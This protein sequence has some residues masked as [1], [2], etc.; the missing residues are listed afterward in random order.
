MRINKIDEA[1]FDQKKNGVLPISMDE[2]FDLIPSR[3]RNGKKVI[4]F[5]HE[6]LLPEF[7]AQGKAYSY[8]FGI[9]PISRLMSDIDGEFNEWMIKNVQNGPYDVILIKF[10][11]DEAVKM[12]CY[13]LDPE[14]CRRYSVFVLDTDEICNID[15]IHDRYG[16]KIYSRDTDDF[17]DDDEYE[18]YEDLHES[19]SARR[20]RAIHELNESLEAE[21]SE[22]EFE[23]KPYRPAEHCPIPET[24]DEKDTEFVD[25]LVPEDEDEK[26][27]IRTGSNGSYHLEEIILEIKK[28]VDEASDGEFN[29]ILFR[30]MV[31]YLFN[32]VLGMFITDKENEEVVESIKYLITTSLNESMQIFNK[33]KAERLNEASVRDQ[34]NKYSKVF[35]SEEE[36][37]EKTEEAETE[38]KSTE[39]VE[40]KQNEEKESD[41]ETPITAIVI[42]VA[43]DDAEKAKQQMIDKGVAEDDI[44]IVDGDDESDDTELV[45][46]VNSIEA[47]RSWLDAKGV[48]L[49][50]MLG[51]EI[52]SEDEEEKESEEKESDDSA[53]SDEEPDLR[54][55]DFDDFF[56][57]D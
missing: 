43:K 3:I 47:L 2:V 28:Y 48:D 26:E 33:R 50:E 7:K 34:F 21:E 42:K 45:V 5:I 35:E 32:N 55:A 20:R 12:T 44:D 4:V 30:D 56:K 23:T 16:E 14:V 46:N 10:D 37:E 1:Y 19:M 51:G 9:A 22:E 36:K 40:K 54:D 27:T 49:E 39:E 8:N 29:D 17:E 6:D 24:L 41:E 25:S 15:E 11:D 31:L 13:D 52:V 57:N 18:T 53:D 38:E